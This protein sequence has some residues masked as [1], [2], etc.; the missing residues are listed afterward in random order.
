MMLHDIT[1]ADREAFARDG[2][3]VVDELIDPARIPALHQAY[4]DLFHGC[5]EPGVRPDLQRLEG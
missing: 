4:D 2:Y 1:T 3:L 5:F